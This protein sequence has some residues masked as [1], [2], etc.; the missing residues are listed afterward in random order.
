MVMKNFFTP[1]DFAKLLR[2]SNSTIRKILK[3]KEIKYIQLDRKILIEE[4][5]INKFLNQKRK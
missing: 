4:D 3:K 2:V 1:S 5:E